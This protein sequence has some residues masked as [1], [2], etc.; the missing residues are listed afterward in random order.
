MISYDY[1]LHALPVIAV[2]A[3]FTLGYVQ[4]MVEQKI[5]ARE[6]DLRAKRENMMK[7]KHYFK[8]KE[9]NFDTIGYL[10]DMYKLMQEY[11]DKINAL[12]AENERAVAEEDAAN[13]RRMLKDKYSVYD[14]LDKDGK[15]RQINEIEEDVKDMLENLRTKD[16]RTLM[17]LYRQMEIKKQLA[18]DE[19]RLKALHE[20]KKQEA[21]DNDEEESEEASE[22]QFSDATSEKSENKSEEDKK[23]EDE[24]D[25]MGGLKN[26]DPDVADDWRRIREEIEKKKREF[27][28]QVDP[29]LSKAEQEAMIRLHAEQMKELERDM[30]KEKEQQDQLL[31]KKMK[32]RQRKDK[33]T[34]KEVNTLEKDKT[35][36]IASAQELIND[37]QSRKAT[38]EAN[39]IKTK[40]LKHERENEFQTKMKELEEER[41]RTLADMRN[42]YLERIRK[43]KDPLEKEKLLEEMGKRMNQVEESRKEEQQRQEATLKKML[44]ERQKKEIRK[45]IREIEKQVE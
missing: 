16:G 38:L 1:F 7:L 35:D 31:K 45:E 37:L 8:K 23:S 6:F 2:L 29:N 25:I 39:G 14:K 3:V 41:Q 24:D 17:D 20:K 9:A 18:L 10:G 43:S 21:M 42:E 12:I 4:H 22:L 34:I 30:R 28:A 13:I 11:L 26:I 33:K 32:D 36:E 15:I 40:T 27:K 5:E 19:E 44:K